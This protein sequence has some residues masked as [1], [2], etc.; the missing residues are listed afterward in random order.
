MVFMV[1]GVLFGERGFGIMTATPETHGVGVVLELSLA[2]VLFT[3]AV[4]IDVRALKTESFVPG[5][6]L[7]IGLPL[8]ILA[9]T[10]LALLLFDGLDLWHAAVLAIALAPT[11]AALGQAVVANPRV[12]RLIRQGLSAESGLNDGLVV[13]VL[14]IAVA[15]G[16]LAAGMEREDLGR[17]F[18]EEIGIGVL[19]GLVIAFIGAQAVLLSSRRDWMTPL[20]RRASV[21]G[22]AV[23]CFLLADYLGGSGFLAA[24][25]GG[26][27]FGSTTRSAYPHVGEHS[28]GIAFIMTLASFFLFG[29]VLVGPNLG[30][31]NWTALGYGV[32]SLTVVRMVPV[33]IS[34]VGSGLS[35]RTNL[36][37]GWFGPRGLASLVFALT[38][39]A[40]S[41]LP[42][43]ELVNVAVGT[44]VALSVVLHGATAWPGSRAY[45]D[46]YERAV[47]LG[48][49][50]KEA[51][52][53]VHL[54]NRDEESI[55]QPA[56]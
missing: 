37:L 2:L 25:V 12:P 31:F 49:A 4:A 36:Y 18:L 53:A 19:A 22:L 24:F 47:S 44:T 32:L 17:V 38:V 54:R 13:P 15:Q 8:T 43:G 20:A 1:A 45:A 23:L 35:L 46:W 30:T 21:T 5:R 6:L 52:A 48:R 56:D 51:A 42:T 39:I 11:D 28:E 10:G 50:T 7:G 27:T 9:G 16:L 29:A 3:D 26:I 55:E 41:G 40:D 33:A 14:A 34:M